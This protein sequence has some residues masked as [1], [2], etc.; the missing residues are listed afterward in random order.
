MIDLTELRTILEG[1][2]GYPVAYSHFKQS[3]NEA[4]PPPPFITYLVVGSSNFMADN[5]VYK[6]L[7]DV[8]IELYTDRKDINAEKK[9]EEALQQYEIPFETYEDFIESEKLYQKIYEVRLFN[10]A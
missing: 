6:Q 5:K 10:D 1:A 7:Q 9:I 4:V 3:E 8:E 2:T